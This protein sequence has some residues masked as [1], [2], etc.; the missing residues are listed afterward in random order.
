MLFRSAREMRTACTREIDTL[1]AK[2]GDLSVLTTAKRWLH[3]DDDKVPASAHAHLAEARAAHPVLDKMA[4]MRD[5][6][7][8]MWSS[9][10]RSREQLATDLQAWCKR[11]EESGIAALHDFSMK[12]RA[13]KA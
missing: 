7:R 3:R 6:L 4:V 12:L 9:T 1:K 10:T 8:Q 11:A 2:R 13:A 5:E